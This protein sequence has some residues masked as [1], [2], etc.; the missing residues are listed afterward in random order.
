[1]G[2]IKVSPINSNS[3]RVEAFQ[4]SNKEQKDICIGDF[5]LSVSMLGYLVIECLQDWKTKHRDNLEAYY[6]LNE[7]KFHRVEIKPFQGIY[8]KNALNANQETKE[9]K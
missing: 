9:V 3:I 7:P 4:W 2:T 6:Y 8:I 1:M 5:E